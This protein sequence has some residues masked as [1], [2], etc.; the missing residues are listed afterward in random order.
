VVNGLNKN[1]KNYYLIDVDNKNVDN[2]NSIVN[3]KYIKTV[4]KRK[5]Y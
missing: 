1:Y 2:L 3:C 5:N 4:V